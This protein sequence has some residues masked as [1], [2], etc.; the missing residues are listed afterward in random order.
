VSGRPQPLPPNIQKA[1]GY[2]EALARRPQLVG[3]GEGRTLYLSAAEE[4]TRT[5]RLAHQ[6]S[7]LPTAVGPGP[8]VAVL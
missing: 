2:K 7:A 5:Y 4:Y 1:R 6:E 3:S 8:G